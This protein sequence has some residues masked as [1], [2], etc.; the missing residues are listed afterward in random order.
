MRSRIGRRAVLNGVCNTLTL[1]SFP[2]LARAATDAAT[3]AAAAAPFLV[4][5][6]Q[7]GLYV[8][9][10][11][12]ALTTPANRGDI[13]NLTVI[14]GDDAAA[15]IDTGGSVEVGEA[16]RAALRRVTDRPLRYVINTHEHPDHS[17][18]N[19]AFAQP[20]VTFV[21]HRNLPRA[22]ADRWASYQRSFT[23]QLGA[24]AIARVRMVP[25]TLLV[26]D[27]TVL[28]LGGRRLV[29]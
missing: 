17:F 27:R 8:H 19:A 2:A 3:G 15:V 11:Q 13:A 21:G 7:K 23:A 25:P 14:V 10:G 22:M 5:A 18:G 28:D 26:A 12:V 16:L 29:L 20:G 1:L 4:A 24:A 9:P 6:P